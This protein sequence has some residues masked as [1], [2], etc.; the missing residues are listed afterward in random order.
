MKAMNMEITSA[1]RKSILL[2]V[3]SILVFG[4]LVYLNAL[5]N[6]LVFD[7][8]PM[9]EEREIILHPTL[10][11]IDDV[12]MKHYRPIR[13]LA[14]MIISSM[15]GPHPVSFHLA[16]VLIH[17]INALMVYAITLKLTQSIRIAIITSLLFTTHP[18]QTDAVTYVSGIRDTLS[19]LFVLIGLYYFMEY[20]QKKGMLYLAIVISMLIMGL[21]VKEMAI[22]LVALI[23][24][25]DLQSKGGV[26]KGKL[27][28]TFLTS[29]SN[30]FRRSPFVY[31]LMGIFI[32]VAL[33]FYLTLHHAS[34]RIQQNEIYWWGGSI[35]FNY[36]TVTKLW[37]SYLIKLIFPH[38][39][40]ADYM[41][42][43]LVSTQVT[44]VTA[45]LAL[46][47][48]IVIICVTLKLLIDHP[49][50][51][52]ALGW[53]LVTLLPV[54]QIFPHHELMAE[55]HLYLPSVGFSL[56]LALG[57]NSMMNQHYVK[58]A[59]ILMTIGIVVIYSFKTVNRNMEWQNDLT[60]FQANLRDFPNAPRS[61]M[62][63]G[64][65][66]QRHNMFISAREAY[67]QALSIKPDFT[68]AHNNFGVLYYQAGQPDKAIGEYEKA[69]HGPLG[70]YVPAYTNLGRAYLVLGKTQEGI[71]ALLKG[72]SLSPKNHEMIV[73][74]YYAYGD[75]GDEANAEAYLQQWLK[76]RPDDPDALIEFANK[77]KKRLNFNN[78]INIY[79]KILNA[80]P[81]ESRVHKLRSEILD[82]QK[83]ME[84]I[85]VRMKSNV[86]NSKDFI[87]LA[88]YYRT[89][90]IIEKAH[91]ILVDAL[92]RFPKD[93]RIFYAF[94][95]LVIQEKRYSKVDLEHVIQLERH[96]K[97]D[98]KISLQ[99]ARALVHHQRID[100]A[101]QLL[102][103]TLSEYSVNQ[104][105]KSG[106]LPNSEIVSKCHQSKILAKVFDVN[107]FVETAYSVLKNQQCDGFELEGLYLERARL[108]IRLNK[109]NLA[110]DDYEEALKMN[111][112]SAQAQ[113][114]LGFIML[115]YIG[116]FES[117]V[118]HFNE[119]LRLESHQI[120]SEQMQAILIVLEKSMN[121]I[122]V[123]RIPMNQSMVSL[124]IAQLI[125]EYNAMNN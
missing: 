78:A 20:R 106:V 35:L 94:L 59:A 39:L 97:N 12:L 76:L 30:I 77:E 118:I 38:P 19:T 85:Q 62:Q 41:G 98:S 17:L 2:S 71:Q 116:D 51:G 69:L 96:Y 24:L 63:I 75:S 29:I 46:V 125:A 10:S 48:L 87:E 58:W 117:A 33:A 40:I 67:E 56:L 5:G 115:K 102:E 66:Y 123:Q 79:D 68:M 80:S 82:I 110:I 120:G 105:L 109:I 112:K 47:M 7:D 95:E 113:A 44:D 114:E 73:G 99:I 4:L 3:G 28:K 100:D 53:I 34:V 108:S 104:F 42:Y 23:I 81:S 27:F 45:W 88:G 9:I 25:Y 122:R 74:L 121:S 92:A 13:D 14:L 18:I 37:I 54:V 93:P 83:E 84:K 1:I 72:L 6:D 36:M 65:F 49:V 107:G 8:H 91:E 52:F 119:S 55:H 32:L 64:N 103:N 15:G 70:A 57:I 61:Y 22:G 111:P 90:G 21:G 50:W 89:L 16:N 60:L 11:S 101:Y 86:V 26:R 43:P 31:L 124:K